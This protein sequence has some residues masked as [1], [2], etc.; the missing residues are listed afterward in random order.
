MKRIFKMMALL[1]CLMATAGMIG[2]SKDSE[3]SNKTDAAAKF[4]GTWQ[5]WDSYF[6]QYSDGWCDKLTLNS[7]GSYSF[8]SWGDAWGDPAHIDHYYGSW[9]YNETLNRLD[10]RNQ[11]YVYEFS[12]TEMTLVSSNGETSRWRKI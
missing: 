11:D 1:L 12:G 10:W 5:R 8:E 9:S 4:Y 3:E 7:D 2:C 6:A